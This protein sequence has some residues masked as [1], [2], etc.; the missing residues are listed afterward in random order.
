MTLPVLLRLPSRW[1]AEP[2]RSLQQFLSPEPR[3]R[4]AETGVLSKISFLTQAGPGS[5]PPSVLLTS[6]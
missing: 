2:S 1:T 6:A 5:T 4:G 3:Q